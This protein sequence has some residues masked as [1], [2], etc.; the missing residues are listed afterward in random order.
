MLSLSPSACCLLLPHDIH[1]LVRPPQG[2]VKAALE[3]MAAG[4]AAEFAGTGITVNVVVPGGPT[5]TPMVTR[6]DYPDRSELIP[7]AAM[8]RPGTLPAHLPKALR[9]ADAAVPA[10]VLALRTEAAPAS[11]S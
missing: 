6:E 11:A 7:P 5:D 3:A 8:A 10:V 9:G 2:P 1:P 4:H